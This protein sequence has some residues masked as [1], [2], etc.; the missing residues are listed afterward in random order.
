MSNIYRK[1]QAQKFR[2]SLLIPEYPEKISN[3]HFRNIS[4]A[5]MNLTMNMV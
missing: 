1:K 2:V 5:I 3:S 4:F